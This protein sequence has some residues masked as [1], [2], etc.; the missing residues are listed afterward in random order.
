MPEGGNPAA[1]QLRR[2]GHLGIEDNRYEVIKMGLRSPFG[3]VGY[4]MRF[5]NTMCDLLDH[6]C[7]GCHTED[8]FAQ[9]GRGCPVGQ[10][11]Y[12]AKDYILDAHEGNV[13]V[14]KGSKKLQ[15][16]YNLLRD[17]KK[18]INPI[19]PRS[20]FNAQWVFEEHKNPDILEPVRKLVSDMEFYE[21]HSMHPFT[22]KEDD[23]YIQWA[24][25]D[26]DKELAK[27]I[28]GKAKELRARRERERKEAERKRQAEAKKRAKDKRGVN[29]KVTQP[30]DDAGEP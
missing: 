3:Y 9:G 10:L 6:F 30:E 5:A 8:D 11:V 7:R 20:T 16:K 27:R 2:Q 24:M 18:A 26:H 15:R 23:H 21:E 14:T 19:E 28:G 1:I 17:L 4:E 12:A 13:D 25:L 29:L 22:M